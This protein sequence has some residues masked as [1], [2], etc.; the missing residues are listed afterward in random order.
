MTTVLYLLLAAVV[1]AGAWR[2][3]HVYRR[4][5]GTR[6]ITCPET[7]RS[8][9]VELDQ[10]EATV[11]GFLGR[12][13][14]Q[15]QNCSRWPERQGCDQA[16]LAQIESA[17]EDCLLGT[18]VRRFYEAKTCAYCAKPFGTIHWHDRKPGLRSPEGRLLQWNQVL[19]EEAHVG[20]WSEVFAEHIFEVL[21]TH[22]PVCW[23]CLM[24]ESF[25]QR[26][27]D[28]VVEV[29]PR[30]GPRPGESHSTSQA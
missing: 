10:A 1:L 18:I 7:K 17:P 24:I 4:A 2:L 28:R 14:L 9:A 22:Q 26:F 23:D 5:R 25:R 3:A 13:H 12:P 27:P 11:T 29:P 21:K 20:E 15:L 19:A 30:P 6:V 8:A 16:C